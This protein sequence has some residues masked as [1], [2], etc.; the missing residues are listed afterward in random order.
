MG[1]YYKSY[2]FAEFMK[3]KLNTGLC[4]I[5]GYRGFTFSDLPEN[6]N[7]AIN[8]IVYKATTQSDG[9]YC[10]GIISDSTGNRC[11]FVFDD[12]FTTITTKV[13]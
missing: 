9:K 13:F 1:Q 11:S 6:L 10:Q 5:S 8:I 3:E 7:G 12:N 2:T 4:I